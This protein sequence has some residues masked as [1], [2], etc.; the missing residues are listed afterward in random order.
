MF[1]GIDVRLAQ[2]LLDRGLV[3]TERLDA[4]AREH[5]VTKE[6]TSKILVRN[7]FV[8]QK[9]M[10]EAIKDVRPDLL[11]EEAVIV[12]E[13]PADVLIQTR[14]MVVADSVDRI[15]VA[16]LS[17]PA[18]VR[19]SLAPFIEGRPVS[20]V[21]ALPQ[22]LDAYMQDL[23]KAE[24]SDRGVL[25]KLFRDAMHK[26]ASDI[27]I[28]PREKTYTVMQRRFG[29]MHLV[30]EG[31]LEEYTITV[32]RIKDMA[33][34][35]MAERRRPQDGAL[36]F[37]FNGRV[38]DMRVASVPTTDGERIVIRI[39]DPDSI[40]PRLDELGITRV[41]E[42]RRAVSRP[43]GLCLI[44]GPTGSGK[45]T[46]LNAT[47]REMSFFERSIY[48]AEDPVEYR[49][50]YA[51][52][53]SM[54]QGIGLDFAGAVKNFMRADPDVIV[55]GE[56]RDIETAR[57]ALKAAETGHLVIA[58]LH[59]GSILGA[60]GRLRDIGVEA[61]E[62][63]HLLRGVMVQRL[64]R[65]LCNHC[66]GKGCK[67]CDFSRYGGRTIVSE[68]AYLKNEKE[69]QKVIDGELSWQTITENAIEKA[70]TGETDMAEV[71]RVFGAEV[72]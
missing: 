43:D 17:S 13:I 38:I 16:S 40:N 3:S 62:L 45:T 55:V 66:S 9:D 1:A 26:K 18:V 12:P 22:R 27:H 20:F 42:W 52:Q 25:E 70:E 33:R 36:S 57:N 4:A 68:V 64:V 10:I 28:L 51:G 21:P 58:T 48:T 34:M 7:G 46:T 23:R 5:E 39:L 53:V 8:R 65:S 15:Y 32:S 37:E 35:D 11:Y 59:T 72:D 56:I 47:L 2:A 71:K 63:K 49:L 30:H 67:H 69:V 24:R 50:A 14:T 6:R 44:C 19:A 29:V 61:Y 31:T 54:N 60:V 41:S